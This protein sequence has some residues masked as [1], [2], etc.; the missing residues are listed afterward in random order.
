MKNIVFT[1]AD[2]DGSMS[3]LL[4]K[5]CT[6]KELPYRVTT[7]TKFHDDFT[8]WTKKNKIQDYNKIIILDLDISQQ[9]LELVDHPNV[10]IVDHHKTHVE[11]VE[12]YKHAKAI[13]QE[14]P[15]C[16]K[17]LYKLYKSK[18]DEA[19]DAN[20]KKLLMLVDDYDSWTHKYPQSKKLNYLFWNYQGDRLE[21]FLKDFQF[22]F[23]GFN[24]NQQRVIEFYERKL[25][26]T[27]DNLAYHQATVSIQKQQVNCICTF[28]NSLI[29]DIGNHLIDD[30]KADIG[31]VVNTD[32]NRVSVRKNTSCSVD[33]GKLSK[34]L[35]DGGGHDQAAGG[36]CTD[37][38]L[39]F[40]K[41]FKPL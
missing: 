4:L 5:W 24:D 6:G 25:Q 20:M 14:Y 23:K 35:I 41:L 11:N 15:S 34:H 13:V 40:S 12:K 8:A 10:S 33:L 16:A 38:F 27:I 29:S 32:T 21:K 18:A 2:L 9:S 3:Y 28:C 22:G 31:F 17:L 30:K 26:K 1:D 7:V 36:V 19:M 39:Q 37:K